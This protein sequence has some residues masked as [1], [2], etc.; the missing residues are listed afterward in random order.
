[1]LSL[2][3]ARTA[4]KRVVRHAG[5]G[6]SQYHSHSVAS[7]TTHVQHSPRRL[8]YT[9][10]CLNSFGRSVVEVKAPAL[11]MHHRFWHLAQRTLPLIYGVSARHPLPA[12]LL[13]VVHV[14]FQQAALAFTQRYSGGT[15]GTPERQRR[16]FFPN[17]G[18]FAGERSIFEGARPSAPQS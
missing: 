5:T 9:K 13:L 8:T 4:V 3:K 10:Q 12:P 6:G 7:S 11:Q 14:Q 17:S 2:K 16:E 1:M 15:R 18:R